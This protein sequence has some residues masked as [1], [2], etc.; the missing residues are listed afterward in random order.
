MKKGQMI[1]LVLSIVCGMVLSGCGNEKKD[2]ESAKKEIVVAMGSDTGGLDPA[3]SIA[4]T[5]LS[6][7]ASALDELLTF[8]EKGQIQYRAAE[9][10]EVNE[11]YTTWTFHL[12]EDALWSDGTPVTAADFVNTIQRALQPSSGSGYV[13]YLF[14]IQNAKDI[15]EG[16]ASM[17]SLG[18]QAKDADTLVFYL[19]TPCTYFLELLRLPV[20]MPSKAGLANGPFYLK[21][22][23][24]GQYLSVEKNP[25]YWNADKVKLERITYQFFDDQ[26]SAANAYETGAVDV[27]VSL[28]SYVMT[29]YEGRADLR[30][31]D[32]I[33]TRYIYPNLTVEP[34]ADVRVRKALSLAIDRE[35]LCK[36]IGADTQPTVNFVAAYMKNK[37]TGESFVS[38]APQPFEEDVLEARELLTQA[39]YPNGEG[40]PVLTYNYPSIEM[41]SDTAQVI[42]EQLK[43]NLNIEI[44]LNAQELQVNYSER[45]KGNFDLCRMNWTADFA[46]PYSYLSM[47]LTDSPYNCSGISDREY[48]RILEKSDQ[49]TDAEKRMELLHQAEQLAVGAEFYVIPLYTMQSC[50][51]IR[52]EIS[53]ITQIAASGALAYRYADISHE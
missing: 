9:S 22:Y 49:E 20:Y 6:Y 8:D 36:V 29:L 44:E 35:E 53:G 38:E 30:V 32:L 43:R 27:A 19:A 24:D 2:R 13:N 3:G 41:D 51:L 23:V 18:V 52:P 40:F 15:Y 39:G 34:L 11:D 12:R 48:D 16:T 37:E 4:L 21:E 50:N 5:Y 1:M 45:R 25:Y 46:D 17:E 47:L 7:S 42:K 31:T 10:Y 26:N 14:G 28:P 33:A